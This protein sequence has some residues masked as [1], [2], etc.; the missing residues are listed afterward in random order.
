M[1]FVF[2]GKYRWYELC[3]NNVTMKASEKYNKITI[4]IHF[5]LFLSPGLKFKAVFVLRCT[6]TLCSTESVHSVGQ[7]IV[8]LHNYILP[9]DSINSCLARNTLMQGHNRYRFAHINI[10]A[11]PQPWMLGL[12]YPAGSI[13]KLLRTEAQIFKSTRN[14]QTNLV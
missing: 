13:V 3:N 11:C 2:V 5:F 14:D 7:L 12:V 8:F 6:G 4:P 10:H 1:C 9:V